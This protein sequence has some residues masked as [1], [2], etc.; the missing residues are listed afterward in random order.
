MKCLS[1]ELKSKEIENQGS[2]FILM[3]D[4]LGHLL[5]NVTLNLATEYHSSFISVVITS[6]FLC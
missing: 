1:V 2:V 3:K 4:F 5:V 6:A